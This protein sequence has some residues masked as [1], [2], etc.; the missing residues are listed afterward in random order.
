MI[1]F[2]RLW[3]TLEKK[4]ITPYRLREDC[5]FDS[6]T[7]RRLRD[8]ENTETKTLN[9]ICSVLGCGLEDIAEYRPDTV[10]PDAHS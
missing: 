1:V 7:M 3:L 10:A 9:T 8:N 4:G 6:K 5:G 2:D